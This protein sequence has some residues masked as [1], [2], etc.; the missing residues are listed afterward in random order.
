MQFDSSKIVPS[1]QER[2]RFA[3]LRQAY[4]DAE[5]ALDD[6]IAALPGNPDVAAAKVVVNNAHQAQ[7]IDYSERYRRL[8]EIDEVENRRIDA[9]PEIAAL[10]AAKAAAEEAYN[11]D[12]ILQPMDGNGPLNEERCAL[13]GVVLL[14]DDETLYDESTEEYVLRSI[15]LPSRADFEAKKAA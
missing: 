9:L 4:Y 3:T 14:E 8:N 12:S 5:A 10:V 6:A 15:V 2:E 7:E 1:P 13:S 11:D